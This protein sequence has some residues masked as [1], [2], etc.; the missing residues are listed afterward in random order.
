VKQR[1][2]VAVQKDIVKLTNFYIGYI[3]IEFGKFYEAFLHRHKYKE[4]VFGYTYIKTFFLKTLNHFINNFFFVIK[5]KKLMC[6]RPNT[7]HLCL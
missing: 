7:I 5:K 6:V 2:Y 4:L 1:S 3:H